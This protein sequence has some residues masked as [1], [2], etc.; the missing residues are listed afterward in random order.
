MPEFKLKRIEDAAVHNV[1][2]NRV[3]PHPQLL[4]TAI[5]IPISHFHAILH[6]ST[7]P[8]LQHSTS[9]KRQQ[10]AESGAF[11][12]LAFDFDSAA[13]GLDDHLGMEHSDANTLFL[14]GL[15]RSK[16]GSL[17]EISA[18]PATVVRSEEHTSEL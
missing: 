5:L 14:G 11:A 18:H 4:I 10:D 9:S 16:Q 17:N 1:I 8:L 13:V 3:L 2:L 6:Q 12:R 7:T 15:K